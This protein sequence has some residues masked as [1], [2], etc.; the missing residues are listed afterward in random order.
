MFG[1]ILTFHLSTVSDF[2]TKTW[3]Q[4]LCY[5][6]DPYKDM[7]ENQTLYILPQLINKSNICTTLC[8]LPM[9]L[10]T[11]VAK[12]VSIGRPLKCSYSGF[13]MSVS[14]SAEI[15]CMPDDMELQGGEWR[16]T[17]PWFSIKISSLTH[18][19]RDKMAAIFQTIFSNAFSWMKMYEFRLRFHWSLLPEVQLIIFQHWFR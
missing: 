19:G 6:N 7:L 4:K 13:T 3:T 17:G 9:A 2:C 10:A 15:D 16:K 14:I 12:C 11:L 5:V 1:G 8:H 18:W